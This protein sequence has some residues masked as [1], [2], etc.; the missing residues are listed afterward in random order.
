M[1]LCYLIKAAPYASLNQAEKCPGSAGETG[2]VCLI[3]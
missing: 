1:G 2:N 3:R